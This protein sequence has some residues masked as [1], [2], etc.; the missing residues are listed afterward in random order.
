MFDRVCA[1]ITEVPE[2]D[3]FCEYCLSSTKQ[4]KL[5]HPHREER[6][7]RNKCL[8][9]KVMYCHVHNDSTPPYQQ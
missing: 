4:I 3:W 7:C 8:L 1:G 5:E 9:Q 2:G 6:I